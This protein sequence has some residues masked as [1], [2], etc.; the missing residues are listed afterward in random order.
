MSSF[1]TRFEIVEQRN[2]PLYEL[3][4]DLELSDKALVPPLG[5]SVCLI[6]AREMTELLFS[7]LSHMDD[8]SDTERIYSCSGCSGL[9]KFQMERSEPG[10]E[11]TGTATL[12]EITGRN[13]TLSPH[14]EQGI[15]KLPIFQAMEKSTLEKILPSFTYKKI[16]SGTEIFRKGESGGHVV[17]I[18]SGQTAVYD[19]DLVIAVLGTGEI[20]GEMSQLTSKPV[21]ATVRAVENTEVLSIKG[22]DLKKVM[23]DNPS[24]YMYFLRLFADRL[25][26]GNSAR[27]HNITAAMSGTL[28]EMPQVELFQIFHMNNKTGVLKLHLPKGEAAISFKLGGIINASYDGKES[29]EAIYR[30]LAEKPEGR[31]IFSAGLTAQE[32]KAA[33]IGEFMKL[34]MDGIH[35]ADEMNNPEDDQ[36]D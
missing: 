35:K 10:D 16:L 3:G 33:D 17:I 21:C 34:L 1:Q 18:I 2:C 28:D 6:L 29:E 20:L 31:F 11:E 25:T 8:E 23:D 12:T 14:V 27:L 5:K 24:L 9:I 4:D 13:A 36:E 22:D 15:H 32:M 30:I 7:L 26:K 19:D